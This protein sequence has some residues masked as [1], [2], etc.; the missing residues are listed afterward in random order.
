M[1]VSPDYSWM[2]VWTMSGED[3]IRT[4]TGKCSY[5]RFPCRS[6]VEIHLPGERWVSPNIRVEP[7]LHASACGK[8]E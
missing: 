7:A 2:G 4:L 1:L 5:R 6:G 3:H 8:P